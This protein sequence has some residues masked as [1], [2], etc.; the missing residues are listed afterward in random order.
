MPAECWV[1]GR[2]GGSFLIVL[3]EYFEGVRMH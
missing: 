3:G 1:R 2:I